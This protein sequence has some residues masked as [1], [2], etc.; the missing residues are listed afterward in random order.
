MPTLPAIAR[1]AEGK[2]PSHEPAV[3]GVPTDEVAV[4]TVV[5]SDTSTALELFCDLRIV[6]CE[7]LYR[8]AISF[9]LA[10]VEAFEQIAPLSQQV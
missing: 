9:T 3:G 4:V 7:L 10:E 8:L 1:F 6:G 2:N 5:V